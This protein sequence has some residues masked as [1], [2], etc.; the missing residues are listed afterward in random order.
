MDG[1]TIERLLRTSDK[2]NLL[3]WYYR[4]CHCRDDFPS[5]PQSGYY[6]LNCSSK[7]DEL[8]S[9]WVVV[10]YKLNGHTAI[11]DSMASDPLEAYPLVYETLC[12]KV[13]HVFTFSRQSQA[14]FTTSCSL[15]VLTYFFLLSRG[16]TPRQILNEYFPPIPEEDLWSNDVK[17]AAF[18]STIY[19][20]KQPE[21]IIFDL[22]FLMQ[23]E[24]LDTKEEEEPKN[25]KR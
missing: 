14:D 2:Y 19:K 8:G 6:L 17:C 16:V 23:R 1:K 10:C 20:I 24:A 11:L 12:K 4:S 3:W 22:D 15:F 13:K 5:N 21:R 25:K 7:V 9:H 18:C